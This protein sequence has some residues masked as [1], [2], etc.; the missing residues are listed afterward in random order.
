M[1]RAALALPLLLAACAATPPDLPPCPPG[2]PP[3]LV[4]RDR[5][6]HTELNLD[7]AV[8]RGRTALLAR[9]APGLRLGFGKAG[10]FDLPGGPGLTAYALAPFP[11]PAVVEA[12]PTA[13]TPDP[14]TPGPAIA[15]P[16]PDAA[17]LNAFLD[18]SLAPGPLPA[19]RFLPAARGYSL[20]YT[21]NT[22]IAE[23]LER[24]GLPV[25]PAGVSRAGGV[26]SQAAAVPGACR[27]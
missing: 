3:A 2:P 8:L 17:G 21:C 11:G 25:S 15:L 23:A 9:G 12:L 1:T 22:W 19:G 26:L 27:P 7:A 4:L 6:I 18:A 14:A 20:A 16:L 13:A 10:F 5:G 24:G